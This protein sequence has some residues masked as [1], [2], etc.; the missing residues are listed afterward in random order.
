MHSHTTLCKFENLKSLRLILFLIIHI[1]EPSTAHFSSVRAI[2][3]YRFCDRT[4]DV[5]EDAVVAEGGAGVQ[6]GVRQ[7]HALDLQLAAA[8][9]CVLPIRY[10]RV[11]FGP[12][13]SVGG[14]RGRAAQV[15]AISKVERKRLHR[16]FHRDCQRFTQ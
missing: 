11:V 6:A 5:E 3:R 15:Q 13:D 7:L 8:D 2:F 10:N 1:P 9:A 14:V 4:C 16:R 12:V